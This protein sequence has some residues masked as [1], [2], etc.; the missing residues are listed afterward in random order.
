MTPWLKG[1]QDS[2]YSRP[3]IDWVASLAPFVPFWIIVAAIAAIVWM[4]N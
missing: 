4:F 2:P 3:R 1:K